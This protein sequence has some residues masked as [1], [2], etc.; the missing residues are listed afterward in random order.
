MQHTASVKRGRSQRQKVPFGVRA[1]ESGIEVD[2]VWISGTNTP[3]TMPGS[4]NIAAM[5][6]QPAHQDYSPETSS[7]AS[8]TS[9]I[10]VPQPVYG[11]PGTNHSS[12]ISNKI[13]APVDRPVSSERQHKKPHPSEHQNLGR[14][15]YQPRRSS[16]LRFSNS[17]DA[18]NSEALAALEGRT[19]NADHKGKRPEG[20]YDSLTQKGSNADLG[21]G[22]DSSGEEYRDSTSWP[23]HSKS[24][25]GSENPNDVYRPITSKRSSNGHLHPGARQPPQ[26]RTSNSYNP[27]R[28]KPAQLDPLASNTESH[29]D[30]MG[31]LHVRN[32][33]SGMT[34]VYAPVEDSVSRRLASSHGSV[35]E[36][37]DPFATPETSPKEDRVPVMVDAPPAIQHSDLFGSGDIDYMQGHAQPLRPFDGNR[38]LRRSQVIRKVNDGFEIL[39]PGTLDNPRR[40]S[41]ITDLREDYDRKP[42]KLQRRSRASSGSIFIEDV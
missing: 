3:S 42:K 40:S 22:S 21:T 13:S 18:E 32:R 9:R 15:T 29:M 35:Q 28:Y 5:K 11:Y 38:Q 27:E 10:E 6:P 14:P 20:R 34:V 36:V 19:R 7:S 17:L 2:G 37:N 16:Q 33:E 41:D 39:R 1:L 23:G 25:S 8:E 24:S 4:P 26:A 31:R 30:E 12:G